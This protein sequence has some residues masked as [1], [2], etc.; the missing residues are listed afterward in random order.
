MPG[1]AFTPRL[2]ALAGRRPA[3]DRARRRAC[4]RSSPAT[5]GRTCSWR[6]GPGWRRSCRCS[7]RSSAT[8]LA[9]LRWPTRRP[10]PRAIV[11]HGVVARRRAGLPGPARAAR[12]RSAA[13]CATCR[14]SRARPI[15]PTPAGPGLTGRLDAQLDAICDAHRLR[16]GRQRRLPVRQPRDDRGGR[17]A[18]GA[19]RASPPRRSSASSTGRWPEPTG[20]DRPAD[21]P[22]LGSGTVTT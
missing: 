5:R 15:R 20:A 14:S 2:W 10:A 4:S 8:T 22:A 1:G 11:V 21:G 12:G 13:A 7:R 6:P 9:G 18:P 16:P 3:P 19:A 17:A